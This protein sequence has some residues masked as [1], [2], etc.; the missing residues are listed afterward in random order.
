VP[1][2][3]VELTNGERVRWDDVLGRWFAVAGIHCDPLDHLSDRGRATWETLGT[4]FLTVRIPRDVP[5]E[6]RAVP[7]PDPAADSPCG[8]VVDVDGVFAEMALARPSEEILVIRPDRYVMAA[9]R[10]EE[11]E[12]VTGRIAAMLGVPE[13]RAVEV[14]S[15][16]RNDW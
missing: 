11:L 3:L 10:A 14:D 6:D 16:N 5:I 13:G 8:A 15:P 12:E 7:G 2:P 1:Q 9:C 4:R